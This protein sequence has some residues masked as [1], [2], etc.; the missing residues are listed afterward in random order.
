MPEVKKYRLV[1]ELFE[2]LRKILILQPQDSAIGI[3]A[4]HQHVAVE[5]RVVYQWDQPIRC[6]VVSLVHQEIEAMLILVME[7]IHQVPVVP[8]VFTR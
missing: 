3:T 1:G 5:R 4:R 8:G 2:D 6:S 7:G